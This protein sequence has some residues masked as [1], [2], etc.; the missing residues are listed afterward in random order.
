VT[1]TQGAPAQ[2]LPAQDPAWVC[3]T[4]RNRNPVDA[5][6]CSACGQRFG[7][8]MFAPRPPVSRRLVGALG[9]AREAFLLVAVFAVWKLTDSL[10]TGHVSTAL[11]HGRLLWRIERDLHLGFEPTVQRWL[12][13]HPAAVQFLDVYY[14]VAHLGGMALFLLWL[15]LRHREAYRRWRTLVVVYTTVCLVV[16]IA[17]PAAP[18]RLLPGFGFVDTAMRYHQSIYPPNMVHGFS[19]QFSTLPSLHVGWAIVIAYAVIA[20]SRSRWRWLILAHPLL[21]VL[22]VIGT[23][24]HFWIDGAAA[25]VLLL[26]CLAATAAVR[27][28]GSRLRAGAPAAHPA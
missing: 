4:C 16:E 17:Y 14:A 18:P 24:N 21:T 10:A 7:A 12:L 5:D 19:D 9:A 6:T 13:P 22:S 11:A 28:L 2:P 15:F 8:G 25:E 27:R 3:L 20:V 26:A 1:T 23:A